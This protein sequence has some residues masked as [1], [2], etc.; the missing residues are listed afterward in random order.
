[1]G[2]GVWVCECV[3]VWV[4]ECVS[5]WVCGCVG[6]WVCGCVGVW[7]CEYVGV[8]VFNFSQKGA[9][10]CNQFNEC[11]RFLLVVSVCVRERDRKGEVCVWVCECV[12]ACVWV[13]VYMFAG[14]VIQNLTGIVMKFCGLTAT[15]QEENPIIFCLSSR[16]SYSAM[17]TYTSIDANTTR[18]SNHS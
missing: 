3:G 14:G 9:G 8:W 5:V 10:L 6:V 2:V 17:D 4:C 7:V 16:L 11:L 13:C 18:P 15:N 12:C 1:M